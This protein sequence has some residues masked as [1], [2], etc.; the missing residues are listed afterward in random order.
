M[1]SSQSKAAGMSKVNSEL[2]KKF[3]TPHDVSHRTGGISSG[4]SKA[5]GMPEVNSSI[6]GGHFFE[7]PNDYG[8]G[9]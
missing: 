2:A 4:S 8:R 7:S 6:S 5:A 1:K 9:V 3:G